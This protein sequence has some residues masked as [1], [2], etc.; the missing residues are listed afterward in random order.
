MPRGFAAILLHVRCIS[1]TWCVAQSRS[2]DVNFCTDNAHRIHGDTE[3][4]TTRFYRNLFAPK[5][6]C[7]RVTV[8]S[9]GRS[10]GLE[11]E[12]P[13]GPCRI[14]GIVVLCVST[15]LVA[16]MVDTGSKDVGDY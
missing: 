4:S 6:R 2:N 15:V 12:A 9:Q 8:R 13:F 1:G 16:V 3:R 14:L 7:S 10:Q 11:Y 5:Y